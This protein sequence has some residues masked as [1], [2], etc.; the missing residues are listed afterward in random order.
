[1]AVTVEMQNTGDSRARREILAGL[2]HVLGAIRTGH[3]LTRVWVAA[4]RARGGE[5]EE[6]TA[7]AV[8]RKLAVLLHRLW[9]TGEVYEPLRHGRSATTVKAAAAWPGQEKKEEDSESERTIASDL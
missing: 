9:V 7:V 4:M 8:A 3:G 2:E 5:C 6:G 1:M